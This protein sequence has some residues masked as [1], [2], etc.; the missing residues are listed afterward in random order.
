VYLV[1]LHVYYKMIHGPYNIILRMLLNTI[2]TYK[3]T[4]TANTG[5]YMFF[6]MF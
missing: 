1:G 6:N 5:I 4:Q 3:K 2:K